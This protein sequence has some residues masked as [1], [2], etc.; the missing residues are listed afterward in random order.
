MV[1]KNQQLRIEKL[2]RT[3]KASD[4]VT[5]KGKPSGTATTITVIPEKIKNQHLFT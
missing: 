2:T 3:A 5:A 1:E 4:N